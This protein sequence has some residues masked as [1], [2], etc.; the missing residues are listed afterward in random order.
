MK[1]SDA[2][3]IVNQY[4]KKESLIKHMLAVEAAMRYYAQKFGEDVELWGNV[5]LLHDFDY[6]IHPDLN[7]HPKEGAPILR[8]AGVP[9]EII[10]AILSHGSNSDAPRDTLLRKTLFACDE[11]TGLITAVV[12]VRPSRSISRSRG[13]FGQEEMEKQELC[14]R[15]QS[16]RNCTR[17]TGIGDRA[18]G[19]CR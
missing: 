13:I 9:E 4:T 12:L 7:T 5:G 2:L 15:C 14:R 17:R 18:M 16:R 8:E 1:R 10:L 19:A 3:A 11:V 6:E